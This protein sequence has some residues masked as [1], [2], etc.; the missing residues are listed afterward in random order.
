MTERYAVKM[1]LCFYL[2]VPDRHCLTSRTEVDEY[3]VEHQDAIAGDS[4]GAIFT[5]AQ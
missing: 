2:L 5:I 3:E 1:N 4:R